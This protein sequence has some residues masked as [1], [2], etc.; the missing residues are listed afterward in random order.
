MSKSSVVRFA[1][2]AQL[3]ETIS[4]LNAYVDY[5]FEIQHIGASSDSPEFNHKKSD[6]YFI[7]MDNLCYTLD[8]HLKIWREIA[9]NEQLGRYSTSREEI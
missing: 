8:M 1:M 4:T 2:E 6:R 3:K 7:A 9:Q 5:L